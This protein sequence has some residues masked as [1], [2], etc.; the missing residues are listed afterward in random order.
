MNSKNEDLERRLTIVGIKRYI[1]A[2]I[3][4]FLFTY[5]DKKSLSLR[6]SIAKVTFSKQNVNTVC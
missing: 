5:I 1:N 2:A 3:I 6:M 4:L